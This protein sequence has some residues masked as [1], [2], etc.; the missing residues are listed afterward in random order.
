MM[1]EPLEPR[2]LLSAAAPLARSGGTP[3]PPVA[4]A[5]AVRAAAVAPTTAAVRRDAQFLQTTESADLLE[6]QLGQLAQTN[7]SLAAVKAFSTQL[8]TDHTDLLG[9]LRQTATSLGVALTGTI[10][11]K[12][13]QTLTRL[14]RLT[15]TRFDR[16][17]TAFMITEARTD[18][19]DVTTESRRTTDPSI[20]ALTAEA[21]PVLQ[22]DLAVAQSTRA[23]VAHASLSPTPESLLVV[24]AVLGDSVGPGTVF[25]PDVGTGSGT[26]TG[27]GANPAFDTLLG[28]GAGIGA[29]DGMGTGSGGSTSATGSFFGTSPIFG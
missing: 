23:A 20:T 5:A 29:G 25:D 24:D 14:S 19:R 11:T 7:G 21:L 16:A 6:I 27:T 8:V 10:N 17:F 22:A 2:Q 28:S 12:G 18:V 9:Q 13:R 26:G 3:V 15:G 1:I 4:R